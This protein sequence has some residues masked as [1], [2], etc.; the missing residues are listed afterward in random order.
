MMP[1][2]DFDMVAYRMLRYIDA[3]LKGGVSPTVSQAQAT[4]KISLNRF[5]VTLDRAVSDG[6]IE[7]D[8]CRYRYGRALP[9]FGSARLTSEGEA[10]LKQHALMVPVTSVIP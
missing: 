6:Y 5:D 4:L 9:L 7:T 3:C 8:G 2:D 10:Y 1:S